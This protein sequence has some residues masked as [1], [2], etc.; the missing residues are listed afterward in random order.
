MRILITSLCGA[1]IVGAL[2]LGAFGGDESQEVLTLDLAARDTANVERLAGRIAAAAEHNEQARFSY[3]IR[4]RG[5]YRA[6]SLI[7]V[8]REKEKSAL[9]DDDYSLSSF[10]IPPANPNFALAEQVY[11]EMAAAES[12]GYL[13]MPQTPAMKRLIVK[14]LGPA[15]GVVIGVK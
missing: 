15:H 4:M 7:K 1:L 5:N 14:V 13:H 10:L 9:L 12:D 2:S 11:K 3:I 6:A 8:V